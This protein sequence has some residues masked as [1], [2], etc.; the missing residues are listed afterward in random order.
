MRPFT[1]S[2]RS[3]Y[4]SSMGRCMKTHEAVSAAQ[5]NATIGDVS[6]I[7]YLKRRSAGQALPATLA[8]KG[9][10]ASGRRAAEERT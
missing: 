1:M 4:S 3:S 8:T 6:D 9:T 10:S 2:S 7:E 5:K